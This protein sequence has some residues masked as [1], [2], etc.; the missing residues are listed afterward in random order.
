MTLQMI[1]YFVLIIAMCHMQF[2]VLC[3]IQVYMHKVVTLKLLLNTNVWL[4]VYLTRLILLNHTCESVSAK[5]QNTRTVLYNLINFTRY[6]NMREQILQFVLQISLRPLQFSGMG[7][8][9]FGYTFT[10]K[11]FL[12]VVTTIIFLMQMKSSP[13]SR[14]LIF[15]GNNMTCD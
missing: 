12:W 7:M 6:V 5:A 8:F 14:T 4:T 3:F 1:S 15:E 2:N 13:I 10:R 9:H 11:F